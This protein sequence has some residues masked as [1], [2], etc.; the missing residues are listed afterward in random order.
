MTEL[1][2][3]TEK[4]Q[5]LLVEYAK[6]HLNIQYD[7]WADI[8]TDDYFFHDSDDMLKKIIQKVHD[9]VR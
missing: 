4:K 6:N 7:K 3:M 5:T 8:R 2:A 9:F 1:S